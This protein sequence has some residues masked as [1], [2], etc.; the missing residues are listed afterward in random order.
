MSHYRHIMIASDFSEHSETIIA[1]A[2]ALAE[3]HHAKLSICHIVEDFPV[4]DFAYE[5]MVSVDINMR[6]A[7]LESGKEQLAKQAT[8]L[9]IPA[10]QQWIECGTPNHDIVRFAQEHD[11][12]LIVVGSHGRQGLKALLGSSAKAILNHAQCD[13]LAVKL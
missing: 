12:D 4:T 5:P 13:V 7:M 8:K 2:Q 9:G 6:D 3:L 10:E 11:V 1:K